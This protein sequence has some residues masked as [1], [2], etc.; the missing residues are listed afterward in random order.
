[1]VEASPKK[2]TRP[3]VPRPR[4][5]HVCT[6][7]G[8]SRN[9]QCKRRGL[10]C[11]HSLR[12]HTDGRL[13]PRAPLRLPRTTKMAGSRVVSRSSP[14]RCGRGPPGL[15]DPVSTPQ[16]AQPYA[17]L[18]SEPGSAGSPCSSGPCH[19]HRLTYYGRRRRHHH[20]RRR[21]RSRGIPASA[22]V[23]A[24]LSLR[25][26]P[27]AEIAERTRVGRAV[28]S[29][30]TRRSPKAEARGYASGN[31]RTFSR[32]NGK[33]LVCHET[34]EA[35]RKQPSTT[36][37]REHSWSCWPGREAVE[38]LRKHWKVRIGNA[39]SLKLDSVGLGTETPEPFRK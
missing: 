7:W 20:D 2:A 32:G 13:D 24:V 17:R 26:R 37:S 36:D 22:A 9:P 30:Y 35:G 34:A 14:P 1:M 11:T 33:L 28:L 12:A 6:P 16:A 31:C 29:P 39:F 4:A 19:R 23:A 27:Q 25:A 38:G 10:R 5:E 18:V 3:P 15:R 21:R 8:V